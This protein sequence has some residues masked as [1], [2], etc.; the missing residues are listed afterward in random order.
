[1]RNITDPIGLLLM[2][3]GIFGILP[4][5][6]LSENFKNKAFLLL[7]AIL[8]GL[9]HFTLPLYQRVTLE[10]NLLFSEEYLL[11]CFQI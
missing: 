9:M 10:I 2:F 3:L 5:M 4:K 7:K 1:M 11:D 6:E 8:F